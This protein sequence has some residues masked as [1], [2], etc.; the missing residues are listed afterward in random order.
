MRTII[1]IAA[2]AALFYGFENPGFLENLGG[3]YHQA[4]ADYSI[5]MTQDQLAKA[6]EAD[7]IVKIYFDALDRE[8]VGY[9]SIRQ[10]LNQLAEEHRFQQKNWI[11]RPTIQEMNWNGGEGAFRCHVEACMK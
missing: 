10:E 8:A 9:K 6:A 5:G 1:A 4:K 7:P 3:K 11:Q 2:V